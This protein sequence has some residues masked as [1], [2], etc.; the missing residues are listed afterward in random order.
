M[1]KYRECIVIGGYGGQVIYI[2][3]KAE[4][5]RLRSTE[6]DPTQWINL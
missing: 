1:E 5:L 6:P 2:S 3:I 4:Y